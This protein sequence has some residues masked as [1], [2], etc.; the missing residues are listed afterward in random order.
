MDMLTGLLVGLG[1]Y[2]SF[3]LGQM[4]QRKLI[5]GQ[6]IEAIIERTKF[7]VGIIEKI[8]GHYYLYEKDTTNFLCQAEKLEDIPMKLWEN[9]QISLAAVMYPEE[10]SQVYW[11]VNGKLKALSK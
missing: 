2:C 7:P 11:C 6:G 3:K 5:A 4:S 10:S 9:K 1:V 8:D